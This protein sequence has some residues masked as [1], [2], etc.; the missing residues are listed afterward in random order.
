MKAVFDTSVRK[1]RTVRVQVDLVRKDQVDRSRKRFERF[2]DTGMAGEPLN[3]RR[4][5]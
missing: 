3:Q 5:A 2:E 4:F 1:D